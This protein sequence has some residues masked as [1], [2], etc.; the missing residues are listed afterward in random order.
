MLVPIMQF[1]FYKIDRKIIRRN[2]IKGICGA[3]RD[4]VDHWLG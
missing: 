2:M 1:Y 3:M 4:N